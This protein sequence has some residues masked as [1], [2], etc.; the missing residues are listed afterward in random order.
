MNKE[1]LATDL[2]NS[3]FMEN[4]NYLRF[5]VAEHILRLHKAIEKVYGGKVLGGRMSDEYGRIVYTSQD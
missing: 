1:H 2:Q 3:K 5:I 4:S